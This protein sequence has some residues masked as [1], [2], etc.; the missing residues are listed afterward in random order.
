MPVLQRPRAA[1]SVP[2]VAGIIVKR[3]ASPPGRNSGRWSPSA[4]RDR[5]LAHGRLAACKDTLCRAPLTPVAKADPS[6][7]H[8]ARRAT[9][10]GKRDRH[11]DP[12]VM[13]L[14]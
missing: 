6:R 3:T 14:S 8:E 13:L 11:C 10:A 12:P 9:R 2:P 7:P 4:R 5:V 1:L